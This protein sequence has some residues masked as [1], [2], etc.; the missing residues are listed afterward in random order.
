MILSTWNHL[1]RNDV[2]LVMIEKGGDAVRYKNGDNGR[3]EC[4]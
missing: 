2:R 4:I 3:G 1:K